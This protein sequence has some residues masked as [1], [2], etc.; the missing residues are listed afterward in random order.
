MN[1]SKQLL[2]EIAQLIDITD[3]NGIVDHNN[4]DYLHDLLMKHFG[5]TE[6]PIKRWNKIKELGYLVQQ[7]HSEANK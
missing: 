3:E 5:Y 4:V 2:E 1:K 6:F 7:L